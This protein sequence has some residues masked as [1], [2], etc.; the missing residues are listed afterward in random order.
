MC[1][2]LFFISYQTIFSHVSFDRIAS[3]LE[4][5][6]ALMI[7]HC[8]WTMVAQAWKLYES[9]NLMAL[10]D[11]SLDPEEYKPDEV[12]R[13]M[14]IALRYTEKVH[15]TTLIYR[16]YLSFNPQPQ[17][18]VLDTYELSKPSALPPSA[19]SEVVLLTWRRF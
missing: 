19:V 10:V 3:A 18:Q 1:L 9:E 8:I 17:N 5:L 13:I 12:Q 11:K 16:R 7:I 15:S 14:E 2:V 4:Y 6:D